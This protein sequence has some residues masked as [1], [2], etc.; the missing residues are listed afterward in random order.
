MKHLL[1]SLGIIF[2]SLVSVGQILQEKNFHPGT[3]VI[4]TKTFEGKKWEGLRSVEKLDYLGR[5]IEKN[6]FR[7]E[8]HLRKTLYEYN[9]KNDIIKTIDYYDRYGADPAQI[10][11]YQYKYLNGMIETQKNITKYGL[12]VLY[13]LVKSV[14]DSFFTYEIIVY[15]RSNGII[16][17]QIVKGLTLTYSNGLIIEQEHTDESESKRIERFEYYPNGKLKQKLTKRIP[18]PLLTNTLSNPK[19]S[20]NLYCKYTYDIKGRV[21]KEYVIVNNKTYKV[22]AYKYKK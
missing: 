8:E 16:P 2:F 21:K 10:M 1:F 22:A 11:I 5:T 14:G 13:N 7:Y 18:E 12:D 4:E 20:D 15:M 9:E 19:Y 6:S 3:S 17:S